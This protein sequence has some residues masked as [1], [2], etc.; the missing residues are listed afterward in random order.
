LTGISLKTVYS[1]FSRK[2]S[3][4]KVSIITSIDS[5]RESSFTLSR[6]HPNGSSNDFSLWKRFENY[7]FNSQE[8]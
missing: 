2:F 4:S 6:K 3:A 7:S 5:S 1:D 8:R